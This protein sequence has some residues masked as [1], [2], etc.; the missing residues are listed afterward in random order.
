MELHEHIQG[1]GAQS[2]L[3]L[4]IPRISRIPW[5]IFQGIVKWTTEW[6]LSS[7][8]LMD[9]ERIQIGDSEIKEDLYEGEA[10]KGQKTKSLWPVTSVFTRCKEND[11]G[12]NF[13]QA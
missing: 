2:H 8:R 10:S 3:I 5:K 13:K 7:R 12:V 6:M 9:L 11:T 1:W 4:W